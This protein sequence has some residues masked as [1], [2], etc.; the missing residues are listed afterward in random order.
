MGRSQ[1]HMISVQNTSVRGYVFEEGRVATAVIVQGA[2]P[3]T[4]PTGPSGG[5]LKGSSMCGAVPATYAQPTPKGE[6]DEGGPA[7][8][9]LALPAQ[10]PAQRVLPAWPYNLLHVDPD[11]GGGAYAVAEGTDIRVGDVVR[12]EATG[13]SVSNGDYTVASVSTVNGELV[14][15][16]ASEVAA[17]ITAKGRVTVMAGV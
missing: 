9:S 3:Y 12:I 8:Q 7:P 13:A 5:P 11:P 2:G 17:T 1:R 6:Q 15:V 10:T 14:F 16:V 4:I